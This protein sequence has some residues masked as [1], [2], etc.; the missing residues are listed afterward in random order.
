M[1]SGVASGVV[2]LRYDGLPAEP[3]EEAKPSAR[4]VTVDDLADAIPGFA[5]AVVDTAGRDEQ[6][7]MR[8]R[9]VQVRYGR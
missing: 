4:I 5:D 9:H 3:A 1:G 6:R 2:H 7:A 8:R